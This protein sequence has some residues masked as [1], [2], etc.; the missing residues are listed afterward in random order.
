MLT[1]YQ[2]ILNQFQ[3]IVHMDKHT[4]FTL[5]YACWLYIIM[6]GAT[7]CGARRHHARNNR[8]WY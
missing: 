5:G 2:D 4:L 3:Q 7:R 1:N 6:D 8:S